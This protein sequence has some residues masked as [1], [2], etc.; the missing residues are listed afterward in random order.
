[1]FEIRGTKWPRDSLALPIHSMEL[2]IKD[3]QHEIQYETEV[4]FRF[5]VMEQQDIRTKISMRNSSNTSIYTAPVTV[6]SVK[7]KPE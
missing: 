7:Q 4:A 3:V 2:W 6:F 1:V 5:V